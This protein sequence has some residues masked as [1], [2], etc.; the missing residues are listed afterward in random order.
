MPLQANRIECAELDGFAQLSEGLK[1]PPQHGHGGRR[2]VGAAGDAA[3][4]Y[5]LRTAALAPAIRDHGVVKLC[6]PG[7]IRRR[8]AMRAAPFSA[9]AGPTASPTPGAA[10]R[11]SEVGLGRGFLRVRSAG[12]RPRAL[13]AVARAAAPGCRIRFTLLTGSGDACMAP[14]SHGRLASVP[15]PGPA[16]AGPS[17]ISAACAASIA[18]RSAI[19]PV[20]PKCQGARG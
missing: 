17:A 11:H 19:L 20:S 4:L 8:G 9:S 12:S 16:P 13:Q 7:R 14:P 18:S 2:S 5:P 6:L 10:G 15:N 3:R 1:R